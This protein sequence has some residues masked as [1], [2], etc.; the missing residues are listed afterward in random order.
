ML[1]VIAPLA[2]SSDTY[3]C[4]ITLCVISVAYQHVSKTIETSRVHQFD[5]MIQDQAIFPDDDP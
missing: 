4:T 2:L 5:I 3:M 1:G